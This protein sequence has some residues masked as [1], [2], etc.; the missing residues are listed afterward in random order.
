M[1]EKRKWWQKKTNRGL[2]LAGIST[3]C[4]A[5]PASTVLVTAGPLVV[6]TAVVGKIF[7]GFGAILTGYGLGDRIERNN[8]EKEKKNEH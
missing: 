6:T 8:Q 2:I 7:A 1:A 4:L 5:F 3:V